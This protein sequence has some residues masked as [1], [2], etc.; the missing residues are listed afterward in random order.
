M[1]VL[2][3]FKS[4]ILR[5]FTHYHNILLTIFVEL[6][7]THQEIYFSKRFLLEPTPTNMKF[8]VIVKIEGTKI[9]LFMSNFQNRIV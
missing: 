9:S 2:L 7:N 5:M 3:K 8:I 6:L 1:Y 4:I